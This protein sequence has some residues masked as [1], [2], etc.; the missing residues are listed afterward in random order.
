MKKIF[1]MA[2]AASA[3]VLTACD[4]VQEDTYKNN[5][6]TVTAEQ[7]RNNSSVTVVQENGKN[8]NCVHVTSSVS[9]P[10]QWFNGVLYSTNPTDDIIMLVTG[11]QTLTITAMNPDGT[12]VSADYPV[13]I[14]ELSENYPVDPHWGMLCGAGSKEWVWDDSDGMCWGNCGYL[15]GVNGDIGTWWGVSAPD[16]AGQISHY[17]YDLDDS[18][19]ATMTFVLAGTKIIKSSG[20]TGTFSFDFTN[21]GW[22]D[23]DGNKGEN[24]DPDNLWAIGQLKAT[25]DGVMFPQHVNSDIHV[26]QYDV[27]YID[28]EKMILTYTTPD[29]ESWGEATFWKFKAK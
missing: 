1:M 8:V 28:D 11:P 17:G 5:Q 23:N 13:N 21:S 26:T 12:L 25:G 19:D 2:L 6:Q 29:Q 3:I 22:V 24:A 27:N 14:E 4:P 15:S 18:G 7:L 16:V 10:I 9:A 20:G